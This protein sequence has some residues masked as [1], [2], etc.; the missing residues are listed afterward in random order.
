MTKAKVV[1]ATLCSGCSAAAVIRTQSGRRRDWKLNRCSRRRNTSNLQL[2]VEHLDF[3]DL[4]RTG[5]S[6]FPQA[7]ALSGENRQHSLL[8]R[9]GHGTSPLLEFSSG[10]LPCE[11]QSA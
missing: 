10:A 9:R 11:K 7:L 1:A 6:P 3:R 4:V 8:L 2:Q 5:Q